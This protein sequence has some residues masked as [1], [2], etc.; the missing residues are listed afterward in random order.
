MDSLDGLAA[1]VNDL[2]NLALGGDW[3]DFRE[4]LLAWYET[5][6]VLARELVHY[7]HLLLEAMDDE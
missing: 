6:P 2:G 1:V 3:Y 7:S 5:N 4:R